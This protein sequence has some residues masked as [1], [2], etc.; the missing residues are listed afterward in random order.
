ML[1]DEYCL[2]FFSPEEE[3]RAKN[4]YAS[5]LPLVSPS[6]HIETLSNQ[7]IDPSQYGKKDRYGANIAFRT[8]SA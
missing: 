7:Q 6:I 8:V 3:K 2:H 4:E 1:Y 5:I